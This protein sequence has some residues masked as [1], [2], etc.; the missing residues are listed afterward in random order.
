[1]RQNYMNYLL[2]F[3]VVVITVLYLRT[4]TFGRTACATD[5]NRGGI[6]GYRQRTYDRLVTRFGVPI[7]SRIHYK[8]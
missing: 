1:M 6:E 4:P 5:E 7:S 8:Y 2:L 3:G